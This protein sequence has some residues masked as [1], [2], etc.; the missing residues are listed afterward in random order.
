MNNQEPTKEMFF[1]QYA[2]QRI[3]VVDEMEHRH[4]YTEWDYKYNVPYRKSYIELK[5]LSSISDEQAIQ[6]CRLVAT[7]KHN[8]PD[9]Y[10][11]VIRF[12][13][14]SSIRV[15]LDN[16]FF[17]E[18]IRI[19]TENGCVWMPFK[20]NARISSTVYDYLRS[21][22]IAIEFMGLS[23]EELIKKGWVKLIEG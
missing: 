21:Q 12:K 5:P 9:K 11:K 13:A 10:F 18:D 4:D 22:R 2:P 3:I 8:Y 23:V 16:D 7:P 14:Y 6:V 20:E 15:K 19:G 17:N 1:A